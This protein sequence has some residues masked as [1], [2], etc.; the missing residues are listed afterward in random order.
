L[1][2]HGA[3]MAEWAHE[4]GGQCVHSFNAL[5]LSMERGG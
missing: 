1:K 3:K 4:F 2:N 5:D